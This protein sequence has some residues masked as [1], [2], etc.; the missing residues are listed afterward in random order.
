MDGSGYP[1]R[2]YGDD[3]TYYARVARIVDVFDALIS[4]RVYKKALSRY[5]A[6]ALMRTEMHR[7]FDINLLTAFTQ[8]MKKYDSYIG[9]YEEGINVRI[10]IFPSILGQALSKKAK[11]ILADI[12]TGEHIILKLPDNDNFRKLK[13]TCSFR[14]A[15]FHIEVGRAIL[16]K[17]IFF[18]DSGGR[19]SLLIEKVGDSHEGKRNAD[20]PNFPEIFPSGLEQHNSSETD[21]AEPIA[22]FRNF[23]LKTGTDISS[24]SD[25]DLLELLG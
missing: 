1:D 2:L 25:E 17:Y 21:P 19:I 6:L 15:L 23:R 20:S 8:Y 9:N 5:D 22:D 7:S 24:L 10:D 14:R 3:I 18:K 16:V 13:T 4:T 12:K 11:S